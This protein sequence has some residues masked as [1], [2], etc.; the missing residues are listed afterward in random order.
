MKLRIHTL[1]MPLKH[2]FRT[3]QVVRTHQN[4]LIVELSHKGYS[5]F[6]EA[7]ENTFYRADITQMK[8]EILSFQKLI[9][10][11]QHP[12]ALHTQ[13]FGKIHNFSCCAVDE[14]MW[15]LYGKVEGLPLYKIWDLAPKQLISSFTIGIDSTK[16]MKEKLLEVPW[17]IYKIKVG[18]KEDIACLR[19]LKMNTT[20]TFRVDA[21]AGWRTE[22][23]IEK[24]QALYEL[25][26]ECIEQP[27]A[28]G[29]Q[30]EA[31]LYRESRLP[32]IADESCV[33]EKDLLHC[34]KYFHGVNI[35]LTKCGGLTAARHLLQRAKQL[36]LKT[37]MGCMVE[38][39]VGISA[40]AQLV[41]LLDYVDMDGALL[42]AKDP[43][44]GVQVRSNGLLYNKENGTG[45]RL[46][47]I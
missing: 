31:H 12:E 7:T 43:A 2:T 14:A 36:G 34:K 17:P 42:L 13:L 25:N 45:A 41:P 37:M 4:T 40:L 27:L 33:T 18:T 21:N 1:S 46:Q 19:T 47:S 28:V 20:A 11:Y 32:L 16:K 3:A 29:D 24:S 26:V 6:G 23:A 10:K 35:K 8:E 44:I 9:E 39:S 22:E 30:G 38:S 5:G 15:D